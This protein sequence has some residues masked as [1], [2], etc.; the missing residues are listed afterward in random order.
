[1]LRQVRSIRPYQPSWEYEKVDATYVAIHTQ[2]S[3][4]LNMR[5]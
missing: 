1:M 5:R 3:D 2:L 4:N